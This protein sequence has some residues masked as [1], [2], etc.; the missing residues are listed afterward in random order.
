MTS[1]GFAVKAVSANGP[2]IDEVTGFEGVEHKIFNLTRSIT[3]FTDIVTIV[4]LA[5]YIRKERFDIVHSHTPKAGFVCMIAG[6][7]AGAEVRLHTIAGI[8][9]MESTG[10]KRQILRYVDKFTYYFAHRVYL[11]SENLKDFVLEQKIIKPGKLKVLGNGSSNG[12]DTAFFDPDAVQQNKQELRDTL[13]IPQSSFVFIFVG[14]V[15]KDKGMHELAKAF[16]KLPEPTHLVLVGPLES[17]LDP[18]DDTTL[19]FFQGN[20]R[21]H[22]LGY[23]KDVRPYLKLADALVF[24]SY[25]EGFPNVPM[26][27]GAMGLPSILT[28]I[29]GCNEIVVEGENGM[30][31][32]P[33]QEVDLYQAMLKMIDKKDDYLRMSKKSRL[34]ISARYDQSM[35]WSMLYEEYVELLDKS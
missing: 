13:G 20:L 15:V 21:V 35:I 24:P 26:Q 32:P 7:L 19:A 6:F 23:Q 34:M 25:R 14:R 29:N 28:D 2:E 18:L 33:K 31:I 8:P 17:E 10:L 11:N 22:L 30:L 5:K 16:K 3:P 1:K 27:A 4:K 9:W 12:I